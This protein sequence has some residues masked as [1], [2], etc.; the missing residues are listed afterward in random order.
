MKIQ[1]MDITLKYFKAI[2]WLMILQSCERVDVFS[3]DLD[4]AEKQLRNTFKALNIF[5]LF[6]EEEVLRP[7]AGSY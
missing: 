3:K 4:D 2:I 7:R 6:N 1:G 5:T